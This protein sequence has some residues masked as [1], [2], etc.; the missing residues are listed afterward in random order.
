MTFQAIDRGSIHKRVDRAVR[1]AGKI[2]SE[3]HLIATSILLHTQQH[4]DYTAAVTLLNGLPRGTRVKALAFWFKHF[5]S[6]KLTFS[7]NEDKQYVGKLDKDRSES[8]FKIDEAWQTTFADLTNEVE[9]KSLTVEKLIK[10]MTRNA[11]NTE[12]H[13]DGITPKVTPEARE[14]ASKIV[15]FVRDQGYDQKGRKRAA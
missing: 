2:E 9:P 10:T 3:I 12:M 7:V 13:D 1:I 4:G 6:E 8:D 15:A 11:V 5:S 14:L